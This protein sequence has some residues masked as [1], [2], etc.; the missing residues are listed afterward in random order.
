MTRYILS[1][2][3]GKELLFRKKN[4]NGNELF[5][6][7]NVI[8]PV[9]IYIYIYIDEIKVHTYIYTYVPNVRMYVLLFR[10]FSI[11]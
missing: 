6:W 8:N 4:G 2:S 1:D 7:N 10:L 11:K 5:L 3:N 9:Y